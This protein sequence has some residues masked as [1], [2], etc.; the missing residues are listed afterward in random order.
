M[1]CHTGEKANKFCFMQYVY[2]YL[3]LIVCDCMCVCVCVCVCGLWSL[4]FIGLEVHCLPLFTYTYL[5]HCAPFWHSFLWIEIMLITSAS[6]RQF[7]ICTHN[8]H[9]I[10]SASMLYANDGED[11]IAQKCSS[12]HQHHS[13]VTSGSRNRI[14]AKIWSYCG[15]AKPDQL[16]H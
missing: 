15:A 7:Y 4:K 14:P 6:L 12:M 10:P 3:R 11:R 2:L 1:Y 9:F 8:I 5:L 13:Y 16:T